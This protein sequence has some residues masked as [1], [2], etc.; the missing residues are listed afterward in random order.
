[1]YQE[2]AKRGIADLIVAKNRNGPTGQVSV[3]W[4]HR[5]TRFIDMDTSGQEAQAQWWQ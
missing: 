2:S 3:L 1:M 4:D 5:H